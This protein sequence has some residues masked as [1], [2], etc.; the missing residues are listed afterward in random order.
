MQTPPPHCEVL[1]GQELT[2]GWQETCGGGFLHGMHLS[3]LK[4]A[5]SLIITPQT[6]LQPTTP[7]LLPYSI[8]SWQCDGMWQVWCHSM[9]GCWNQVCHILNLWASVFWFLPGLL[10]YNLLFAG[11]S[12]VGSI[13]SLWFISVLSGSLL[14]WIV[15]ISPFQR[16]LLACLWLA[17]C[18]RLLLCN[19]WLVGT[20]ESPQIGQGRGYPWV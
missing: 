6:P 8:G 13:L 7:P 10:H 20:D 12:A 11:S 16:E 19:H 3:C 2:E 4:H 14:C 15:G 5:K 17:C 1:N 18:S 9:D